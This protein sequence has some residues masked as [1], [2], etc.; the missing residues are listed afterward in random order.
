VAIVDATGL[1]GSKDLEM[2]TMVPGQLWINGQTE[3]GSSAPP[4]PF[5]GG[6]AQSNIVDMGEW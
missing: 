6:E 4:D 2:D 3:S 5:V 1:T